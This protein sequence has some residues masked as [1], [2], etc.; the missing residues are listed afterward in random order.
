MG[1]PVEDTVSDMFG[2]VFVV[3]WVLVVCSYDRRSRLRVKS[4]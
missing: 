4:L 3:S 2:N 1:K